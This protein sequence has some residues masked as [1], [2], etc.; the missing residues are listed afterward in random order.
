MTG[1][2]FQ[3][4][5]Q[6]QNWFWHASSTG[7][8]ILDLW[9]NKTPICTAKPSIECPSSSLHNV[10]RSTGIEDW[11]I[12][13]ANPKTKTKQRNPSGINVRSQ[14]NGRH[15][16]EHWVQHSWDL[17]DNKYYVMKT[18]LVSADLWWI[19]VTKD[20]L[21]WICLMYMYKQVQPITDVVFWVHWVHA[22]WQVCHRLTVWNHCMCHAFV[23][24]S[25]K[26]TM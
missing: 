5:A 21:G 11:L 19:L 18:C 26:H 20:S 10:P 2:T 24:L 25:D 22:V 13:Y 7:C 14:N 4:W 9:R 12:L 16:N 8:E 3:F 6:Y 1:M 23:S 17:L 15:K